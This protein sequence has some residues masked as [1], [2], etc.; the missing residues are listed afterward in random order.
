MSDDGETW[1]RVGE[2]SVFNEGDDE[3]FGIPAYEGTGWVH[4][5]RFSD[6]NTRGRWVGIRLYTTSL[7]VCD[8]MYVMRGDHDAEGC[9]MT[10]LPTVDFSVTGPSMH[11]HKPYLWFTTNINSPNPIGLTM[12]A[13]AE[14]KLVTVALD[15]PRGTSLVAGKVGGAEMVEAGIA[16][17]EI[18]GGDF[19]R[20]EF[21]AEAVSSTKTW[22]RIFI[23]G[24]W[25]DGQEGVLRYR[26]TRADGTEGVLTE[27]PLM[28]VEVP[29]TERPEQLCVGLSWYGLGSLKSW[30][31]GLDAYKQRGLNTVTS[32]V[33]WMS[34]QEDI[35]FWEQCRDEGFKLLNIDSTFHRVEKADEIHCQFEDGTT[36]SRLCPSYRGANYEAEIQRVAE[37]NARALPDY[38]FADVELWG[39]RGPSDAAKCTRCQ[40]DFK[41]SGLATMEEW[42]KAK[43]V[44]MWGDVVAATRAAVAE[45][46]GEP[47]EIG[48]YDWRAGEAYQFTWDFDAMYPDLLQSSQVSTY[49]PLYPYHLGLIGD[50][51]REDRENLPK[52]DVLPWLTPGDSGTFSGETLRCALLECFANGARGINY[53]SGRVWDSEM[54]VGYS[55]AIRAA[56]KVENLIVQGELIEGA[57]VVGIGRVRAWSMRA[58]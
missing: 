42:Q 13:G 33:H 30:P 51:V 21:P 10:A 19:T 35:D 6:L 39:W 18:E 28:A 38:F 27:V 23:A 15:L 26:L 25:P 45:E 54:L 14:A 16:G 20:Y 4:R 3:K 52:S 12:P 11:F 55:D 29:E 40:A 17:E 8:E 32:F 53:W 31:D 9:D 48:V 44:E 36:G 43:G 1:R 50:R 57:E 22:G 34:D 37:E 2:Y 49:T 47:V 41:A 24:D 5:F 56:G 46:G 7:T 58:R